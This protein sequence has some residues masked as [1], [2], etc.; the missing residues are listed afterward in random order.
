M[1][2]SPVPSDSPPDPAVLELQPEDL[3][4]SEDEGADAVVC[5]DGETF[6]YRKYRYAEQPSRV[7]AAPQQPPHRRRQQRRA[8]PREA[9]AAD[10]DDE[11]TPWG[12]GRQRLPPP[13]QWWSESSPSSSSTPQ[14]EDVRPEDDQL[15]RVA[16]ILVRFY[17]LPGGMRAV[18]FANGVSNLVIVEEAAWAQRQRQSQL[19]EPPMLWVRGGRIYDFHGDRGTIAEFENDLLV[20]QVEDDSIC[21]TRR[22]DQGLMPFPFLALPIRRYSDEADEGEKDGGRENG[23]R[24]H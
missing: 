10:S 22:R 17:N 7:T 13:L 16:D 6:D 20:R 3:S 19:D 14:C 23:R 8:A 18:R 4:S 21:R 9:V 1:A 11:I 2:P 5:S 12:D 15:K 24:A